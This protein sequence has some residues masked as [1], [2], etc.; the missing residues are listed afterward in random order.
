MIFFEKI[1]F[2][3]ARVH[4]DPHGTTVVPGR[5][6]HLSDPVHGADITGVDAQTCRP[7]L[8]RLDGAPIVKMNIGNDGNGNGIDDL[9]QRLGRFLI[10]TGYAHD[11]G[12]RLLKLS[13]LID[14]RVDVG[15]QRIGHRLDRNERI[16]AHRHVTDLDLP[17]G[18]ARNVAKGANAHDLSSGSEPSHTTLI[19]GLITGAE[20]AK[21]QAARYPIAP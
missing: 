4:T 6:H 20:S 18:T 13:D 19:L 2:Q 12:A 8:G 17:G 1:P 16:A 3:R 10:G 5:G 21:N 11:F 7:R 15:G 14:R 9:S